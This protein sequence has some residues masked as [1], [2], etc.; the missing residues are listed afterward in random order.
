VDPNNSAPIVHEGMLGY[1]TRSNDAGFFIVCRLPETELLSVGVAGE[2]APT[3]TL[4]I[5]GSDG[6]RL[7]TIRVRR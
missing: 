5:A 6:A 1:E 3:D 7:H 2:G 4:T